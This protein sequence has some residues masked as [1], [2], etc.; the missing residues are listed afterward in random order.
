MRI[1][2]KITVLGSGVMGTG[3]AAHMANAGYQVMMLDLPTQEEGKRRNAIAE[4]ALAQAIKQKPAPFY[5]P[6]FI[7]RITTGN[8]EDDLPSIRESDWIIEVIVEKLDVKR[9]L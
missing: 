8:F 1:I 6:D 3:I 7:Q 4:Q 9:A 2:K 5:H